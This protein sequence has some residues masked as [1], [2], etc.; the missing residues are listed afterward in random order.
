MEIGV[1]FD[2]KPPGHVFTESTYVNHGAIICARITDVA[3]AGRM[4][5]TV[6]TYYHMVSLLPKGCDFKNRANRSCQ[7][8]IS[9]ARTNAKQEYDDR[10]IPDGFAHPEYSRG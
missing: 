6:S 8:V 3:H 4:D 9:A 5:S 1:M 7:A 10:D 2:G